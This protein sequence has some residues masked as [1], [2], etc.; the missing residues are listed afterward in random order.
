[1]GTRKAMRTDAEDV[2][3]WNVIN[4]AKCRSQRHGAVSRSTYSRTGVFL[5]GAG[6]SVH[7]SSFDPSWSLGEDKCLFAK[8]FL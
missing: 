6:Q 5:L 2:T 1:M 7:G 4:N 3:P 8:Y